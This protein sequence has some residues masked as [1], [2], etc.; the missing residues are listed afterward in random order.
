MPDVGQPQG[1][2]SAPELSVVIIQA[3]ERLASCIS[4]S[5]PGNLPASFYVELTEHRGWG[6]A[7]SEDRS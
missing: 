7:A 1:A 6:A 4:F 3:M 5:A 2:I